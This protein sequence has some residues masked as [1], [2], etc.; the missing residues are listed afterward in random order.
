MPHPTLLDIVGGTP[1]VELTRMSPVPGVRLFAKLEGH[2]PT[3]SVKDRV[4]AYM[5]RHA[6]ASGAL[7]PGQT[8][9]EA[10][11]GNTAIAL[12]AVAKQRGYRVRA[13]VPEQITP[14]MAD[15]LTLFGVEIEWAE[16]RAGMKGPIETAQR[17]AAENGWWF[18][19]QFSSAANVRAHYETTGPE[20]LRELPEVDAFVAGIG[21]GGT[22]TGVGRRLKERNPRTRIVG[23]EPRFGE[24][25][26]GIRSLDEGYVPPLLDMG[27]M[28]GRMLVGSEAAFDCVRTL[29]EREG[30]F[31]GIS[32]GA[33]LHAALRLATQM[34]RGNIVVMFADHGWKY[35]HALPWV[36]PST[37]LRG[38]SDDVAWW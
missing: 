18:A 31:A 22:V 26:Q 21:T 28:D 38:P 14:G 7:R 11:T 8:I 23:V 10:S 29:V 4:A 35:L 3:G 9:V 27:L 36:T 17:L 32:S 6:E 34:E 15:L 1:L 5:V 30:L 37:G 33:T 13:V 25:L 20:I 24:Q 2:N 19:G 12:A 16:P